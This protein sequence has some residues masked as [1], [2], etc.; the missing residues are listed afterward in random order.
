MRKKDFLNPKDEEINRDYREKLYHLL[1][2]EGLR[3]GNK[4]KKAH[5]EWNKQIMKVRLLKKY[6]LNNCN[7][8]FKFF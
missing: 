7:S 8:M 6:K 5:I 4:L 1:E 3:A 2:Q